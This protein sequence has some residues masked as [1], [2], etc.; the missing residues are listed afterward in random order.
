MSMA[1]PLGR[2]LDSHCFLAFLIGDRVYF[3]VYEQ[4]TDQEVTEQK[5][6]Y[7]TR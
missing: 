7:L 1:F 4:I 6:Y 3:L 2:M 5:K